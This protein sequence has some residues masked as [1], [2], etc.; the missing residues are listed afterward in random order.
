M[1][2]HETSPERIA[3]ILAK[4]TMSVD[5]LSEVL[6]IGRGQAYAFVREGK[7]KTLK[8]GSRILIPTSAVRDMLGI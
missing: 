4:P 2:K 8:V 5:E 3:A 7:I 1:K 6:A